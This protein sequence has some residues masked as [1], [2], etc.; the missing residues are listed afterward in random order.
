MSSLKGQV[1]PEEVPS[2]SSPT[3][4]NLGLD[5]AQNKANQNCRRNLLEI[6]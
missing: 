6:W 1:L 3:L 4:Y 5:P 2:S